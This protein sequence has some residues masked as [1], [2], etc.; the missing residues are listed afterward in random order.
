MRG[1]LVHAG[2]KAHGTGKFQS[3]HFHGGFRRRTFTTHQCQRT[4]DVLRHFQCCE[5]EV[6]RTLRRQAE[7]EWAEQFVHRPAKVAGGAGGEVDGVSACGD[8]W[9][10]RGRRGAEAQRMLLEKDDRSFGTG[11][12]VPGT[13][14]AHCHLL[15]P[16]ADRACRQENDRISGLTGSRTVRGAVRY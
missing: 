9:M 3:H 7:E 16:T 11:Y 10:L 12:R 6:V 15:L 5:R 14:N 1:I 2:G 4:G 8:Q 13:A